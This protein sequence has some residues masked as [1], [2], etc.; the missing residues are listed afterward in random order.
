MT[1]G[2][3]GE[4]LN[5]LTTRQIDRL[6]AA[7]AVLL[8]VAATL[9]GLRTGYGMVDVDEV[10]YRDTLVS[11]GQG[12]G[13]YPAMRDALVAKEGA[14]PTQVRSIRPPTTFLLLSRFPAD[15]WRYLVG[16]VYLAVLLLA[17]RLG[18]T[19]HTY[20]GPIAVVLAGMWMLGAAEFLFLHSE[21]WGLPF[22]LAGALAVRN[23]RWALGAVAV[24]LAAVQR[25]I[26][27]LALLAGLVVSARRWIWVTVVVVVAGL[28]LLHVIL[29]TDV[30]ADRGREA[31]FGKSG[32]GIR[33]IL[34]ALSPSD[35]AFGWL[36]GIPGLVLGFWGLARTWEQDA[37]ARMLLPFA[38]AMAPM[39]V[40]ASREYWSLAFGPAL[41]CYVPAALTDLRARIGARNWPV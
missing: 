7:V 10:V 34:S 19:L 8:A 36:I 17:R 40:F 22:L 31:A 37:G 28:G 25:E 9:L 12:E 33:Y 15:S 23:D 27:V 24:G 16:G 6:S 30:L 32:L 21:L 11:M 39:T 2:R 41:A 13:Y 38:A 5:R 14:P 29:A 20:G 3:T 26:F 1:S 35:Q 18:R 4:D